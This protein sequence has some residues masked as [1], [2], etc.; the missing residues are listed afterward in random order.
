MHPIVLRDV[1]PNIMT[2]YIATQRYDPSFIASINLGKMRY[3]TYFSQQQ[4]SI[5]TQI[6]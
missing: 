4:I 2:L 5:R 6:S 3:F 1:H